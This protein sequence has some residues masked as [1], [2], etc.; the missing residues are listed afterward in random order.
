MPSESIVDDAIEVGAL[1]RRGREAPRTSANRSSS[2]EV[3]RGARFGNDLL[4]QDVERDCAGSRC[5]S[6]SPA[7]D[8]ARS[9]RRTRAA[10]RGWWRRR[11]P[12]G[13]APTQ[14]PD[15]PTRCR[16]TAIERGEPIWHDQINSADVDPELQRGSGDYGPQL[17]VLQSRLGIEAQCCATGCRDEEGRRSRPG[18][19]RGACAT[20][21]D[22]RRVLTKMSVVR[23]STDVARRGDR[24]SRPTSHWWHRAQLVVRDFDGEVHRAAVSDVDDCSASAQESATSSIGRTV[25]ERPILCGGGPQRVPARSRRARRQREVRAA[26]VVG[27]GVDLV[28][29]QRATVRQHS[30]GLSAVSRMNSDSGVVTRMCGGVLRHPLALPLRRVAGA[31]ARADGLRARSRALPASSL[32]SASGTSR[33]DGCRS[34]A[35]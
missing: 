34:T 25:A 10:R 7:M 31:D 3:L 13:I 33:F 11:L 16:A 35:P 28:D 17:A 32:I 21:S 5:R 1:Q 27:H 6:S 19:R 12:R 9:A 22:S 14:W 29:D 15:R 26:F 8:G 30:R 2:L 18:V 23:C 20:R 4:G 24:R